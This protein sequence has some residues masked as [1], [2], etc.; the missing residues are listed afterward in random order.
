MYEW[1]ESIVQGPSPSGLTN[2]HKSIGHNLTTPRRVCHRK[3]YHLCD[4]S[5]IVHLLNKSGSIAT[6]NPVYWQC[7]P[8]GMRDLWV[9][10]S[11]LGGPGE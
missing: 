4:P 9:I 7:H 3:E 1:N 11:P 10:D 2:T 5:G 6:H 8:F